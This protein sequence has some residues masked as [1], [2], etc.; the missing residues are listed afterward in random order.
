VKRDQQSS[1][2]ARLEEA[3]GR[4]V[5]ARAENARLR[6]QLTTASAAKGAIPL[7]KRGRK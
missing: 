2:E 7:R 3:L 4:L 1:K 5:E 6:D